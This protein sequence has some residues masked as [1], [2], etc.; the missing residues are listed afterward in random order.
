MGKKAL[1]VIKKNDFAM[2]LLRY[3][4]WQINNCNVYPFIFVPYVMQLIFIQM[5]YSLTRH[6][7]FIVGSV[8]AMLLNC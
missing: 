7:N 5:R 6:C 4:T 3:A 8:I 1:R 2:C